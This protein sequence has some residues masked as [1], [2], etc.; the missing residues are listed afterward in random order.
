MLTHAPENFLNVRPE[1]N[2]DTLF[3]LTFV[4]I[5]RFSTFKPSR[6]RPSFEPIAIRRYGV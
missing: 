4:Q 2:S 1:M 5:S 3:R 6:A